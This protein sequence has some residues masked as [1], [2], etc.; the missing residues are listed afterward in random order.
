MCPV[1]VAVGRRAEEREEG[2]ERSSTRLNQVGFWFKYPSQAQVG[3]S[4]PVG[5]RSD[6]KKIAR[7][8]EHDFPG[9]IRGHFRR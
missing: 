7:H 9:N 8:P 3:P 5:E 6:Q 1:R 4:E 2:N